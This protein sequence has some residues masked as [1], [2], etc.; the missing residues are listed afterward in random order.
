MYFVVDNAVYAEVVLACGNEFTRE[1]EM[2]DLYRKKLYFKQAGP[3]QVYFE[4]KRGSIFERVTFTQLGVFTVLPM[5]VYAQHA[6][7]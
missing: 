4:S 2:T 3:N 6:A 1:R 7:V 5:R